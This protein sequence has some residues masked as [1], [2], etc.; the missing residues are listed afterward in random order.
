MNWTARPV[1]MTVSIAAAAASLA[2]A[3]DPVFAQAV[4]PGISRSAPQDWSSRHLLYTNPDTRDEAAGKGTL[5]FEQWKQKYKDPRFALQVAR[6][7]RFVQATG[8]D[9]FPPRQ[10]QWAHRFRRDPPPA[11]TGM[12]RDWSYVLGGANSGVGSAG[13]FP[14][15]FN[16][17]IDAT[18]SCANDFVVYT[19]AASGAT[20]AAG[21][22]ASQTGTFAAGTPGN[23]RTVTIANGTTRKIVLTASAT[24]NTGT[25][26]QVSS[27]TA[28]NATN[29]AD[30]I[31]RNANTV[32]VTATSAAAVVTV[33]AMTYGSAGNSV[34]L[35]ENIAGTVFSWAGTT[36]AGGTGTAGQPTVIA[37]NQLYSSCGATVPATFWSYNTGDAAV[38]QTSPALSLD[39]TQVAFV[40]SAG[41]AASLVLLKWSSTVSVGT[42]GAPS[43][44]SSVTPANYRTCAAP[45]MTLIAFSGSPNDTNS[46]PYVDYTNDVLYVGADDGTLHKF[47][48]VF[49]GTPAES[50]SPWP[51]AASAATNMLSSP[52][53][54]SASNLVF[55]GS[56]SGTNAN[57]GG[58]LHAVDAASGALVSSGRL[59]TNTSGG[60]HDAPIVDSA[61]QSVYAFV[62]SDRSGTSANCSTAPCAAVYQFPTDFAEA[63]MG[64]KVQVGRG[65][66]SATLR[67]LY[68]GAFDDAYYNSANSA[69]PS[70]N[71]YVC[72]S[73]AA[74]AARPTLWQI[75]ITDNVMGTPVV[76]PSLVDGNANCSPMTE[77]MNGADDYLFVSIT[78]NGT[79]TGCNAS[80]ATIGCVYM[81]DLT[82]LT[83]DAS[84]VA[85]AGLAAPGGASGII[86]DNV[87]ST[88][89]ASQIYY[90]TLTNPGN[91]IQASQAALN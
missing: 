23:G 55:V 74:T 79:N 48:D 72:G 7:T 30:A 18:P 82:G 47:T 29:L 85:N 78:A 10:L 2:A 12:H 1:C 32:G 31:N 14:A 61:A 11:E 37:F 35:A 69:S 28:T 41:S 49:N 22:L 17:D 6:K 70:G 36:L 46:S 9:P 59:A 50:G 80:S 44:P 67:F 77:V 87:S 38:T 40:Q 56:A 24:L 33:T 73:L 34:T 20:A 3:F 68:A 15:K 86:I 57:A 75:P 52:V 25:N 51:V 76:G 71:L 4:A 53:Y 13:D 89:G 58:Q 88:T 62:G 84:A 65:Q 19:T 16:F 83:W 39:G 91:A 42:I 5:S 43:A 26:F 21:V 63:S 54:D 27:N 45:C 90:S 66:D 60:V 8:Q 64:T 81:F